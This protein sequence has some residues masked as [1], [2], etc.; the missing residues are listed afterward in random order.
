M[1]LNVLEKRTMTRKGL[2]YLVPVLAFLAIAGGFLWGLDPERAPS[3]IPSALIDDPV[4]EFT[5][6]ALEGTGLPGFSATNLRSGEVAL[7]NV[8]ASWCIPCRAEHPFL[9]A[10]SRERVIPI[11]GINYK[12]KPSDALSWLAELG[13]P[14]TAIGVDQGGRTAID[15][16]IYGVP[17]TF[18]IDRTG[19]IRY[20]HVGPLFPDALTNTILPL[21]RYLRENG[22]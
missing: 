7:V 17:E 22:S 21:I 1:F 15:W 14:Y 6:P 12:D 2:I 5:L 11:Y 19:V 16:G 10:L 20:R 4:P 18:V 9:M 8:F 3:E 13:N